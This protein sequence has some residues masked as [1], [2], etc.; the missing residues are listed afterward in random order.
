M[1]LLLPRASRTLEAIPILKQYMFLSFSMLEAKA[2]LEA[3][4]CLAT[5]I[6]FFLAA[7]RKIV[8]SNEGSNFL[9]DGSTCA[10]A[11]LIYCRSV[12]LSPTST[13]FKMGIGMGN[14]MTFSYTSRGIRIGLKRPFVHPVHAQLSM[15]D[16]WRTESC[17]PCSA[18]DTLKPCQGRE[19]TPHASCP[20]NLMRCW[21]E[22]LIPFKGRN[23]LI[24]Y[25]YNA[26]QK[27]LVVV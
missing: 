22:G 24:I 15:R 9:V 6:F 14:F 4:S 20:S 13:Y 7:T 26:K 8:D 18:C 25:I 21:R 10:S 19:M 23:N 16:L 27:A 11:K 2:H 17:S 1:Q 12:Y 5:T 3:P